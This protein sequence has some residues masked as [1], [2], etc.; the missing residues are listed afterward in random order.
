M[1]APK[2]FVDANPKIMAAFLA[3]Q[4]EANAFIATDKR[5]AAEIFVKNAP[6]KVTVDEVVKM[7]EDP[8][9]RFSTT[10]NGIMNFAEFLARAGTIK[11]KPAAWSDM[12][13]PALAQG[14][15][16]S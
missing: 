1:F 13:M 5:G 2:A 9:T 7:L 12:F 3:A 15:Q 11:R 10:P 6:V 14:R 16:G 4:D 8:D